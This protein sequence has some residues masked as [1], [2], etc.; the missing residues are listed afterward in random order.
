MR[1]PDSAF[2]PASPLSPGT[3]AGTVRSGRALVGSALRPPTPSP[4]V[5]RANMV[6]LP[7]G[8]GASHGFDRAGL[9]GRQ[10]V[11]DDEG[12]A[13]V[14]QDV[15]PLLRGRIA[16]SGDVDRAGLLVDAETDRSYLRR[17]I[18]ADGGEP[19]ELLA[20]QVGELGRGERIHPA[21]IGPAPDFRSRRVGAGC[22]RNP[23]EDPTPWLSSLPSRS[24]AG[25]GSRRRPRRCW[26][27]GSSSSSASSTERD[28]G[29]SSTCTTPSAAQP[30]RGPAAV[31][32]MKD[33]SR[34]R[35]PAG[36]PDPRVAYVPV[37]AMRI[38]R[39][40][41]TGRMSTTRY[42]PFLLPASGRRTWRLECLLE[43]G[44]EGPAVVMRMHFLPVWTLRGEVSCT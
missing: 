24:A 33:R 28:S 42:V 10:D 18:G 29:L 34:A 27:T 6:P 13:F 3:S 22:A 36:A 16:V 5:V 17:P 19:R 26:N 31:S 32:A 41:V 11:V 2:H 30:P 8:V 21:T 37:T 38:G 25:P 43:G 40:R 9:P 23:P 35:A 44:L 39:P 7:Q 20:T 15:A 14:T 4:S 12:G 1:L